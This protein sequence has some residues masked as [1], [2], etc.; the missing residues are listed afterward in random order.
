MYQSLFCSVESPTFSALP[1]FSTGSIHCVKEPSTKSINKKT[2]YHVLI[3]M[4][5][6]Y[7]VWHLFSTKENLKNI[8]VYFNLIHK[9]VKSRVSRSSLRHVFVLIHFKIDKN[10]P[11]SS[12]MYHFFTS[13]Y[14][15]IL[16]LN[17]LKHMVH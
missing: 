15:K 2:K 12:N 16:S 10:I 17:F 9:N 7:L 13:K 3:I 14:L 1:W 8:W 4:D 5:T 6:F 11:L